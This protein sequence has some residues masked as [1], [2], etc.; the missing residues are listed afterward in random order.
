MSLFFSFSLL[1]P[2][3]LAS[4]NISFD[5]S[6]VSLM[7]QS[8]SNCRPNPA[9][10]QHSSVKEEKNVPDIDRHQKAVRRSKHIPHHLRP[11]HI[12]ERRNTRERRR[13]QDVNNAFHRLQALL[14]IDMHRKSQESPNSARLSKVHTLRKA[15]DY[16][17]ALQAMLHK[18]H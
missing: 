14:P 2:F 3:K 17:V 10:H 5:A 18:Y 11:Q 13:V 1:T 15:V 16:I 7:Y 12:V 8:W 6:S 9:E 4:I